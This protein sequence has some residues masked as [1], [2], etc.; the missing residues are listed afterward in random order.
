MFPFSDRRHSHRWAE[1]SI[2]SSPQIV[3][4]LAVD[5]EECVKQTMNLDHDNP[6]D[7]PVFADIIEAH[8][9]IR[10]LVHRTPVLTSASIDAM[11]GTSIFFKC[12][13]LQKTGAF[14][15]R[16]ATNAVFALPADVAM[17]GVATHSSGNHAAA[18]AR[19]AALR[20]IPCHIVMPSNAPAIKQSAVRSYGANVSLS[21]PTLRE[22]QAALDECIR[23]TGAFFIHPYNDPKVI[24]GQGTAAVEFL[25]EHP[26]LDIILTPLGGGGLLSGTTIAVYSMTSSITVIGAEPELAD[27]AHRSFKSGTLQPAP[28]PKT[29][30]DGL[31]TALSPRTFRILQSAGTEVLCCSEDA[32]I[33][34]MRI[35]WTRAKL[36]VEASAAVPLATVFEHP[37]RF[38]GQNLGIILSGGNVDLDNLP[39]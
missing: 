18:L 28:P 34:A 32:I 29:V 30:A 11:T 35:L 1:Y 22:R 6:N 38:R 39:W 7:D 10:R 13:H 9:R 36:L 5:A 17:R 16:G 14:K 19:A 20:S 23:R 33:E 4:D 12:E 3:F 31:R 2:V 15:A 24:A 26:E 37:E 25:E 27:D 8:E 21:G